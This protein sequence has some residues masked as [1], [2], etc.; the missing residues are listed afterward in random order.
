MVHMGLHDFY[1]VLTQKGL[2]PLPADLALLPPNARI[3]VDLFGT[4]SLW[5]LIRRLM[6]ESY[7]A[8]T[9]RPAGIKVASRVVNL[10]GGQGRT[11]IVHVEG[12]YNAEKQIEHEKRA[13]DFQKLLNK[14][15][16]ALRPTQGRSTEAKY[17]CKTVMNTIKKLSAQTFVFTAVGK[18]N[19]Y[20]DFGSHAPLDTNAQKSVM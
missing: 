13:S 3:D 9:A 17:T 4:S 8:S 6:T 15:D 16:A 19:F 12:A 2:K 18:D 20:D 7:D 11:I 1:K 10:F 14:L 5:S